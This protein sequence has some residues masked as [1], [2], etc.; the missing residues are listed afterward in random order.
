MKV[1]KDVKSWEEM[2]GDTD[3]EKK[4]N[5]YLTQ[6]FTLPSMTVLP[7]ECLEEAKELIDMIAKD[8]HDQYDKVINTFAKHIKVPF[9]KVDPV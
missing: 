9:P 3:I 2:E 1:I 7:D 8:T 5:F 6:Q 4:V